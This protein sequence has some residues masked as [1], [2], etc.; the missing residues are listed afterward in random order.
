MNVRL[1]KNLMQYSWVIATIL[2]L[3]IGSGAAGVA[4]ERKGMKSPLGAMIQIGTTVAIVGVLFHN[5]F[6]EREINQ[7]ASKGWTLIYTF[8]AFLIC[9]VIS[10]GLAIGFL[11]RSRRLRTVGESTLT[12]ARNEIAEQGG[13]GQPA[14]RSESK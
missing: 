12:T 11:V 3:L 2:V 5:I 14:T 4:I 1:R 9:V 13:A 8:P 7:M 10:G 6:W